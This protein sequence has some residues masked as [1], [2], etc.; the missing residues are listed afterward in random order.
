MM[1][2]DRCVVS[3]HYTLT[4]D[5]GEQIDTSRD[6]EPLSYLHGAGNIIPGLEQALSGRSSGDELKVTVQ[7]E[8]AY[9]AV[10][11]ELV[12]VVPEAAFTGVDD[13]APG[14]RFQATDSRGQNRTVVVQAIVDDGV[15]VDANHPL[16][17]EVLHFDVT[18]TSVREATDEEVEHGHA[19]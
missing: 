16:A 12:Q 13:I 17:G 9:G 6:G 18:V 8:D 5:D 10:D 19:H 4:N 14:M 15:V 7:P 1:I 11:P 3:I 2:D